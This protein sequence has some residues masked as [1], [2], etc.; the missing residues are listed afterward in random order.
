M[1]RVL[2][3]LAIVLSVAFTTVEPAGAH[4]T[5]LELSLSDQAFPEALTPLRYHKGIPVYAGDRV[6]AS[7]VLHGSKCGAISRFSSGR[8]IYVCTAVEENTAKQVRA[9][10]QAYAIGVQNTVV[11]GDYDLYYFWFKKYSCSFACPEDAYAD[12][13]IK[14]TDSEGGCHQRGVLQATFT[15]S[16]W[17]DKGTADFGGFGRAWVTVAGRIRGSIN[18]TED[19][20]NY[21]C[22]WSYRWWVSL[23]IDD[24]GTPSE[25]AC[26]QYS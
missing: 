23:R 17:R 20:G 16:T 11:P 26:G 25:S 6:L 15:G 7:T 24:P 4:P 8:V 1:R 3:L 19:Q 9:W 18:N 21:H 13:W 2:S 5:A 22:T 10:V 12:R 14:C